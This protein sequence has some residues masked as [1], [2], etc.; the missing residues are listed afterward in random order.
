MHWRFLNTGCNEAGKNMAIDEAILISHDTG[1]V[2]PTLRVYGWQ[3]PT[4]SL[5]YAQKI[6]SDVNLDACHQYGVKIIRRPTGG[7]AVLHDNEVTYSVIMPTLLPDGTTTL[8]EHYRLIGK[9]LATTLS[10]LGL[11][12]RLTRPERSVTSRQSPSPA[13][14][15]ALS[16]YELSVAGKKLVGSAQKRA[17][18]ALLQH[19]SIPF[20]LDRQLLFNCLNV[21]PEHRQE[22][23]QEAQTTMTAVQEVTTSPLQWTD[24]Y[25]SLR[26]GFSQTFGGDWAD[27]PL[28]AAEL[29]L[30]Q[31]LYDTKYSTAEWN[32]EGATAWRQA[33]PLS[34]TANTIYNSH[35]PSS[36]KT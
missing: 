4:L 31:H 5:G 18:H 33:F 32:L 15:T 34:R 30:A 36:Y 35:A 21:L 10:Y 28:T 27:A 11:P 16:R 6:K 25:R 14:F 22:L 12:V 20:I 9:A 24:L 17:Q 2:P 7:R 8:T 1:S 3:Q 29:A 19:G 13:C 23:I 26:D